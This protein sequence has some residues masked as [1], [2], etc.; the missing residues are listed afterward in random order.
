MDLVF[1]LGL[2]VVHRFGIMARRFL[3][4]MIGLRS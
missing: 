1:F 4:A 3:V 2:S